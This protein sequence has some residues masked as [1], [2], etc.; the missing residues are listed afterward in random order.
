MST[1]AKTLWGTILGVCTILP[2]LWLA[3]EK[4]HSECDAR[5]AQ[6][7]AKAVVASKEL[8]TCSDR[9]NANSREHCVGTSETAGWVV[10]VATFR[11]EDAAS[12]LASKLKS[13]GLATF[14]DSVSVNETGYFRVRVGPYSNR[15]EADR[16][17]T[18]IQLE[19]GNRPL[20][21]RYP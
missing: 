9:L 13:S 17:S 7:E 3:Y 20:V 8:A 11:N 19:V 12:K 21:M 1:V 14:V 10:Q 16:A 15:A 4:G 6:L 18:R 5:I 2:A